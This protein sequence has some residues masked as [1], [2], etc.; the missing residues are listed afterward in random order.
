M[1]YLLIALTVATIVMV[2]AW[3]GLSAMTGDKPSGTRPTGIPRQRPT[4]SVAPD[5]DVEF[6]DEIDRKLRGEDR[7]AERDGLAPGR[8][9]CARKLHRRPVSENRSVQGPS[10]VPVSSDRR[11]S[12]ARRSPC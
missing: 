5:D 3:R 1:L 7:A 9:A 2:L 10:V 4:R 12:A 8:H 6:L 11:T